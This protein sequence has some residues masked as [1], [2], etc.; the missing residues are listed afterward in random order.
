MGA[1]QI[2]YVLDI[3]RN[4]L[5]LGYL[6][7]LANQSCSA[8]NN[9]SHNIAEGLF[10]R[11]TL[12]RYE[13]CFFSSTNFQVIDAEEDPVVSFASMRMTFWFSETIP[14]FLATVIAV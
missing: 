8:A 7:I 1:L 10:F 12:L 2:A 11:Y 6:Y 13:I 5:T 9:V 3:W 4:M 14:D